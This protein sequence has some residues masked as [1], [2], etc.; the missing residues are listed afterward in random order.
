MASQLHTIASRLL[1]IALTA[2]PFL[3]TASA[4]IPTPKA[5]AYS[6][7]GDLYMRSFGI[8]EEDPA[9]VIAPKKVDF[10]V[11]Q[12]THKEKLQRL[13]SIFAANEPACDQPA[14]MCNSI[15]SLMRDIDAL[16]GQG[17]NY[18]AH[19]MSRINATRTVFG[20]VALAHMLS[21]PLTDR[22]KLLARQALIKKLVT[23]EQFFQSIDALVGGMTSEAELAFLS[24][25]VDETKPNKMRVDQLYYGAA[26][27]VSFNESPMA[28]EFMARVNDLVSAGIMSTPLVIPALLWWRGCVNGQFPDEWD[29]NNQPRIVRDKATAL[30]FIK[31]YLNP[32]NYIDNEYLVPREGQKPDRIPGLGLG[33]KYGSLTYA[34]VHGLQAFIN[35]KGFDRAQA[36]HDTLRYMQVRLMGVATM[37]NIIK[38]MQ[39]RAADDAV[40]AQGFMHGKT[41]QDL[42]DPSF[43]AYSDEY[44]ALVALLQADTFKGDPSYFSHDGNILVA[45]K[46]MQ[47]AKGELA[48]AM[49]LFGELD[50]CLSVAKL[51]KKFAQERVH[52]CFVDFVEQD[53]PYVALKNFWNPI[54]DPQ[55]VVTND[56][57][58]GAAGKARAMIV[59]GAN[60]GGKSTILKAILINLLFAQT[61]GIAPAEHATMTPFAYL[62]SSMNINDDTASGFSLYQAEVNRATMLLQA[63]RQLKEKQFGFLVVDELFRGTSPEQAEK[64][65]YECVREI[66]AQENA[67]LVFA[68]HFAQLTTQLEK[69]TKG[70]CKN[71]KVEIRKDAQGNII[72]PFKL[73]EGVNSTHIAGDI[74]HSA[75][76]QNR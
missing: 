44:K 52:Y 9:D 49:Q 51:Y 11:P 28:L 53:K 64:G 68:T 54:V 70:A 40:L 16:Y 43:T 10:T 41:M 3:A 30:K 19:L 55:V 1:L 34:I 56:I 73:E 59:T 31:A 48:K 37:V 69:E 61:F 50:A 57:E 17:E 35:K 4:K 15:R 58:L 21:R 12:L 36:Q 46:H 5:M 8:L 7:I 25:F 75:L 72:R 39:S 29:E 27:G 22:S 74:L 63:V 14:L 2:N 18:G 42:F 38:D 60:T 47:A 71:Y 65:S 66:L 67:M 26:L 62:G 23:D 32:K 20:E 6:E 13:Y 76:N 45:Y 24:L 33:W